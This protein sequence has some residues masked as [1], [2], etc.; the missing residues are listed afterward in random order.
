MSFTELQSALAQHSLSILRDKKTTSDEFRFRTRLITRLLMAEAANELPLE[1]NSIETPI[2]RM[3]A[4]FIDE[5][6]IVL[7]SILRAGN[8]MLDAALECF[9]KAKVGQ[10]GLSRNA[11]LKAIE[12]YFKVPSDLNDK[13]VFVLDPMLATGSSAVSA[14]QRLK[15]TGANDLVFVCILAAPEGIERIRSTFSNIKIIAAAVDR[16]LNSKAYICPGLGDAGDRI[17]NTV[18]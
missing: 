13:K 16:E 5:T 10:I 18:H 1:T 7:A 2:E 17:Y 6:K 4:P 3:E 11:E 14:I 9:P 12:Y 8:G 15:D